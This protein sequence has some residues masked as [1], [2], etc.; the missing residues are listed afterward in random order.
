VG[1]LR[2]VEPRDAL[3]ALERAGGVVREGKGDHVNVKMP[4]GRIITLSGRKGPIKIGLLKAM[5]RKA[6][7][8]VDEFVDL[9]GRGR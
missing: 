5:L 7:L 1:E 3:R 6:E 2:D 8:S 4:N 9:M